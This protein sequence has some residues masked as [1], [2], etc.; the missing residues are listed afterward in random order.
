MISIL[1]S[2]VM[3]RLKGESLTMDHFPFAREI[4]ATVTPCPVLLFR[5]SF[6]VSGFLET[7]LPRTMSVFTYSLLTA[8]PPVGVEE[9][10]AVVV[11]PHRA[12]LAGPGTASR[13]I[14]RGR[15]GPERIAPA[16]DDVPA[17]TFGKGD[18]VKRIRGYGLEA[19]PAVAGPIAPAANT[20]APN[21]PPV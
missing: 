14:E 20:A 3:R 2:A 6:P 1:V 4:S 19:R 9:F 12:L 18:R 15:I 7:R 11:V 5:M 21:A 13:R 8:R 16:R 17:V 10:H